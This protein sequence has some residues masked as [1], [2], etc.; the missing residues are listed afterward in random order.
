MLCG[1][2]SPTLFLRGV[3]SRVPRESDL[4]FS[5][6][7]LPRRPRNDTLFPYNTGCILLGATP[8]I[9]AG[10]QERVVPDPSCHQTIVCSR[11][12]PFANNNRLILSCPTTT[13]AQ[14][15]AR[16]HQ[17]HQIEAASIRCQS[18]RGISFPVL[19]CHISSPGKQELDHSLVTVS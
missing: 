2:D 16:I 8:S 11:S 19:C 6:W 13:T 10:A 1:R 4:D 7:R 18:Q 9:I 12:C 14:S 15:S 5:R 17:L 3:K